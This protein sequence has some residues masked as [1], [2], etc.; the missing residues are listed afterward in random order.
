MKNLIQILLVGLLAGTLTISSGASAKAKTREGA[1]PAVLVPWL[2]MYNTGDISHADEIFTPDF[3]PHMPAVMGIT[4]RSEYLA[5]IENPGVLNPNMILEDLV[6]AGDE[7]VG[8]FAVTATWPTGTV[9]TN[10]A[11]CFFRF[12]DGRIAE[13]WWEADSMGVLEQVGQLPPTRPTYVWSSPS[14]VIG[15]PGVPGQNVSLAIRTTQ[16][17][18][19]GNSVLW[20]RVISTEYANHDP[21]AWYAVDRVT[22]AAFVEAM[23]TAFP[24][25][26]IIIE[27][28][29]ASGDRVAVRYTVTGTQLGPLGEIPPTGRQVHWSAMSIFRIADGK[30]VEGWWSKDAIGLMQQ[31]M[32]P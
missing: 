32:V 13:E 19:A 27:D 22:T 26:R 6:V 30:I 15:S 21:V 18:N 20:D 5:L 9:Y 8:R 31:L 24:D 28:I 4:N 10:T 29:V 2:E 25:Q 17:V 14:S 3:A 1:D 11:I 12:E 7:M 23:L 16:A